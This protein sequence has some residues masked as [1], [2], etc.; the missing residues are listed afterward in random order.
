VHIRCSLDI[1]A[2]KAAKATIS[3]ESSLDIFA[4]KRL[5]LRGDY[6]KR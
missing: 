5:S 2:A 1:V 3:L 4:A 6:I